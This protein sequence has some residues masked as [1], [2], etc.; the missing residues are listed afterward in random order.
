M[1]LPLIGGLGMML[2]GSIL[3]N[4]EKSLGVNN[5]PLG[6][7]MIGG[8]FLLALYAYIDGNG[9]EEGGPRARSGTSDRFV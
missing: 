6:V 9:K 5:M 7:L 8:G 3:F 2:I 1:N 4:G